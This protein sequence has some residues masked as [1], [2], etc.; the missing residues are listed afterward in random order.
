MDSVLLEPILFP[1]LLPYTKMVF[2]DEVL[3]Q[4]FNSTCFLG[5]ADYQNSE[6][7]VARFIKSS[8]FE[9]VTTTEFSATFSISTQLGFGVASLSSLFVGGGGLF[10]FVNATK[11]W[12]ERNSVEAGGLTKRKGKEARLERRGA[13]AALLSRLLRRAAGKA[14]RISC[15]FLCSHVRVRGLIHP[16]IRLLVKIRSYARGHK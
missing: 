5:E 4:S 12:G 6:S 11:D 10:S 3:W 15:G 9:V 1:W 7:S 14:T 2:G 13:K 8:L 16:P